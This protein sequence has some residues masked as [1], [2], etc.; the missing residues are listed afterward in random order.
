MQ[1]LPPLA[2]GGPKQ[3]LLRINLN[4]VSVSFLYKKKTYVLML[5]H[6]ES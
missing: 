2:D 3:Y 5:T 1:M 4:L 6:E